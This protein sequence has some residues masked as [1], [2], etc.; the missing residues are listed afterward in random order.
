[1]RFVA[2]TLTRNDVRFSDI[3]RREN[4]RAVAEYLDSVLGVDE[5]IR[6]FDSLSADQALDAF[7]TIGGEGLSSLPRAATASTARTHDMISTR[8]AIGA[9]D[10]AAF[11]PR[12][13]AKAG[14]EIEALKAGD[15]ARVIGSSG[16]MATPKRRVDITGTRSGPQ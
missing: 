10:S 15:W 3:A 14:A 11:Q 5:L 12:A 2:L 1:M 7:G 9:E 8:L 6:G 16:Q 13:R 4:E